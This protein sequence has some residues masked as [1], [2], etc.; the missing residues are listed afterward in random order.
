[1]KTCKSCKHWEQKWGKGMLIFGSCEKIAN[2]SSTEISEDEFIY[3]RIDPDV[4][5]NFGCIHHEEKVSEAH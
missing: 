5:Q 2:C 4:G 1:M 3:A